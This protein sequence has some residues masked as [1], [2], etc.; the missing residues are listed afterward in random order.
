MGQDRRR[1]KVED[2]TNYSHGDGSVQQEISF[3]SPC[4]SPGDNQS[5]GSL[6]RETDG[7]FQSDLLSLLSCHCCVKSSD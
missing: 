5:A 1:K 6:D 2:F 7:S 4:S 3:L